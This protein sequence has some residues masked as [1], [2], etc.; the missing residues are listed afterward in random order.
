[1]YTVISPSP[2][3]TR[4]GEGRKAS[5]TD[6][7]ETRKV[8]WTLTLIMKPLPVTALRQGRKAL[9]GPSRLLHLCTCLPDSANDLFCPRNSNE[10]VIST[11]LMFLCRYLEGERWRAPHPLPELPGLH[12]ASPGPRNPTETP[13]GNVG[14]PGNSLKGTRP[15]SVRMTGLFSHLRTRIRTHQ[16]H[17]HMFSPFQL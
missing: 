1:M 12:P 10:L 16:L 17:R 6:N 15:S 13:A 7:T 2:R 3:I 5:N 4:G 11:F 8:W 14:K 9:P